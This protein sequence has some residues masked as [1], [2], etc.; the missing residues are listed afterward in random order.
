M[1]ALEAI[2]EAHELGEGAAEG[3]TSLWLGA[4][5]LLQADRRPAG[6]G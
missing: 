4:R 3:H 6:A 2:H 5:A 1:T